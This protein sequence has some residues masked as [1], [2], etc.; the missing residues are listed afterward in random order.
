[1]DGFGKLVLRPFFTV[2]GRNTPLRSLAGRFAL[3]LQSGFLYANW[4]ELVGGISSAQ[5][6]R[7]Q[8]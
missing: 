1:M 4:I 3:T 2:L 7:R 6:S 5:Y 8:T